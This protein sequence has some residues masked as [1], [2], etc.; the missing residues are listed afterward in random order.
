M[1]LRK[2]LIY[3]RSLILIL[4]DESPFFNIIY[5]NKKKDKKLTKKVPKRPP[6][7]AKSEVLHEKKLS[8]SLK[9]T[10]QPRKKLKFCM[11][12]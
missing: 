8:F 5:S 11:K 3:N 2:D 9:K 12:K 1:N 7:P 10:T 4:I 6:R